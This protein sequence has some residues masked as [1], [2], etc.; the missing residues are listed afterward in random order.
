M[1]GGGGK[2]GSTFGLVYVDDIGQ[3]VGG[4]IQ[5]LEQ[6][7]FC[8]KPAGACSTKGH[9]AKV[10]LSTKTLYVKH[11]QNGH[12]CLEP[13]LSVSLMPEEVTVAELMGQENL[14]EVW[15]A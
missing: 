2:L 3:I 11:T 12:A 1:G 13:S 5:N 6:R 7:R 14:L 15:V 4:V 9:K 10:S 8:C